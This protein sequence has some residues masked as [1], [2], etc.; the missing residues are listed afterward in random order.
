MGEWMTDEVRE[1]I[2]E[3]A[4]QVKMDEDRKLSWHAKIDGKEVV[5]TREPQTTTW[6]RFMAW[7]LK[8]VPESQL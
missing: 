1:Q 4:Y 2:P 8:I 6:Q 7:F 3:V 5:E